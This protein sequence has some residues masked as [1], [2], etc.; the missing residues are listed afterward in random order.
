VANKKSA[1]YGGAGW[2]KV[3]NPDYSQSVARAE[4]FQKKA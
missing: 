2:I 4:L 3:L 1:S